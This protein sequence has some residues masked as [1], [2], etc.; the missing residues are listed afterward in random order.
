MAYRMTVLNPAPKKGG[1][2]VAKSKKAT[3]KY[4]LTKKAGLVLDIARDKMKPFGYKM[5][6][7]RVRKMSAT[8]QGKWAADWM[9]KNAAW[10]DTQVEKAKRKPAKK[11]ATKRKPAKKKATKTKAKK[12]T[13]KKAAKKVLTA[14]QTKALKKV[15]AGK[16]IT[17]Q[18]AGVLKRSG[19]MGKTT[20]SLT[21]KGKAAAKSDGIKGRHSTVTLKGAAKKAAKKK[22]AKKKVAKKKATKKPAKKKA[23]KK[24]VVKRAK[25]RA[26]WPAGVPRPRTNLT[27]AAKK[28]SRA[29][30]TMSGMRGKPTRGKNKPTTKQKDAASRAARRLGYAA[31]GYTQVNPVEKVDGWPGFYEGTRSKPQK[32]KAKGVARGKATVVK[33]STRVRKGANKGQLR[34]VSKKKT[35]KLGSLLSRA[36]K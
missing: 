4:A 24:K 10:I 29:G 28:A 34:K 36:L 35:S 32:K 18:E 30:K 14:A 16:A 11:K 9:M 25:R 33:T 21:A 2:T 5:L 27:G 6:E 17:G 7:A 3:K 15:R 19:L 22:V 12:V 13:K 31:Q 23:A 8:K 26:A 1:R 20:G